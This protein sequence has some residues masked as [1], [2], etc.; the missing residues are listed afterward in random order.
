M[1][2][3]FMPHKRIEP[4]KYLE[5]HDYAMA[6]AM[7]GML[8]LTMLWGAFTAG[9]DGGMIYNTFPM[10]DSHWVPPELTFNNPGMGTTPCTALAAVQ[11]VHRCL[12]VHHR[13]SGFWP[14]PCVAKDTALGGS[15]YRLQVGLG[16]AT[17]ISQVWIPLAALHQ[18]GAIILLAL[19]LRR[20]YLIKLIEK[21]CRLRAI[22]PK[23]SS[24][25][26]TKTDIAAGMEVRGLYWPPA[27]IVEQHV[28]QVRVLSHRSN[29]RSVGAIMLR[30][31][32]RCS[33]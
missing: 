7:L 2:L 30:Y 1:A 19:L 10:M 16:V 11:F 32:D 20:L 27:L 21:S 28:L 23:Q 4:G 22:R 5:R 33:S 31:S 3:D 14:S 8:A 17:I 15:G 29:A 6:G 12:A 18:A 24:W 9:L 25:G 13:N 26:R